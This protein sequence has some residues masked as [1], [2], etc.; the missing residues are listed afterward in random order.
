MYNIYFEDQQIFLRI[1]KKR[2]IEGCLER[3]EYDQVNKNDN[4]MKNKENFLFY[5]DSFYCQSL[6][7][8]E[9]IYHYIN[10]IFMNRIVFKPLIHKFQ[11]VFQV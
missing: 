5:Q 1:E 9:K 7:S 3:N 2:K 6:F 10:I 11:E 8:C 4:K